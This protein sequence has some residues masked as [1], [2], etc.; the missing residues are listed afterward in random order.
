M[1]SSLDASYTNMVTNATDQLTG[2]A[3]IG[4]SDSDDEV[5]KSMDQE[6]MADVV[7]LISSEK[8]KLATQLLDQGD[9]VEQGP[10]ETV[11]ENPQ[12][13]Y[14]KALIACIP[15]L[16]GKQRRLATIDQ[17]MSLKG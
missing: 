12:H 4:F 14:T 3:G 9:I 10:V 15:K 13:P 17:M 16:G 8:N 7:A 6:V 1:V 11:L 2:T 5:E